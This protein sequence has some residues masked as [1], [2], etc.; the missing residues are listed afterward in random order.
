MKAFAWRGRWL[1]SPP[2]II[3]TDLCIVDQ[4]RI[5]LALSRR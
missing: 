5:E 1:I 3:G 4:V 2:I